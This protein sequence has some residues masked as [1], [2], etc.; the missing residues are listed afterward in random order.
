MEEVKEDTE[1]ETDTSLE[2]DTS[3]ETYDNT[4]EEV[5]I[6]AKKIVGLSPVTD[7]DLEYL[8]RKLHHSTRLSPWT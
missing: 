4:K 3:S 8:F 5:L 1:T 2:T 7:E 6:E